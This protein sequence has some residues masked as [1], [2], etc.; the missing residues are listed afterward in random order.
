M[1]PAAVTRAR[2][3]VLGF[4]ASDRV[5]TL[6]L[7]A[8]LALTFAALM[9]L[10]RGTTFLYDDWVFWVGADRWSPGYLLDAY[11][12]QPSLVPKVVWNL[13]TAVF[14]GSDYLPFRVGAYLI[15]LAFLA[16]VF[17]VLRPR[18][19]G[20][21]A[22]AGVV[23]FALMG[24]GWLTLIMVN[25]LHYF[26][27][28]LMWLAWAIVAL[29]RGTRRG[30]AV[31]CVLL[32]L[33]AFTSSSGVAPVAA[34]F[35]YPL[36]DRPQWR[37]LWVPAVPT[38]LFLL[39]YALERPKQVGQTTAGDVARIPEYV[40]DGP[41]DGLARYTGLGGQFTVPLAVALVLLLIVRIAQ[42]TLRD[43]ATAAFAF[44]GITFWAFLSLGRGP[45]TR[46]GTGQ[47]LYANATY[48]GVTLVLAL[49]GLVALRERRVGVIALVLA[50]AFALPNL[51]MLVDVART[52]RAGSE[53]SLAAVSV[54]NALA[55]RD[56]EATAQ[57]NPV[58]DA[59]QDNG[60]Q[61]GPYVEELLQGREPIG[62]T[63]REIPGEANSFRQTFDR[64]LAQRLGLRAGPPR[65]ASGVAP[66]VE[67][68][69]S[70][71]AA[72][73]PCQVVTPAAGAKFASLDVVADRP[74]LVASETGGRADVRLRRF[75]DT[76]DPASPPL[77]RADR[78]G[79]SLELPPFEGSPWRVSV[80]S[81][82]P[83]RV[84]GAR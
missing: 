71:V 42:G 52:E 16:G 84:C 32:V 53:R 34:A 81:T 20:A 39:W 44:G 9:Y 3:R 67:R 4:A 65:P 21:V 47:Y 58:I 46:V 76:A 28:P 30:D 56:P 11:N 18:V 8:L 82:V 66:E 49:T 73:G 19:G 15:H 51:N 72:R 17:F 70:T 83:F 23:P 74:L 75:A 31:A 12:G 79:V 78:R 14:G 38:A 62:A 5:W 57:F 25:T 13:T 33:S 61:P 48:A 45:E 68:T 37:R 59:R 69:D 43:R 26:V 10:A 1:P 54:V 80:A 27:L 36:W 35:A 7:G 29:D 55:E 41:A 63:L 64:Y 22:L 50:V 40:I 24:S 2:P 6:A 77:A 60:Y